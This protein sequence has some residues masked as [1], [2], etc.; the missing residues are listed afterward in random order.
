[1]TSERTRDRMLERLG[2]QGIRD[3]RVLMAMRQVPRHLFV[4]DALAHRA[5][6][7]TALPIAAGQTISQPYIVARMTELLMELRPQ[8][9][10]EVGTGSGYQA[11]VLSQLVGDVYTFERIHALYLHTRKLLQGLEYHNIHCRYSDGALAWKREAPF[12][13]IIVTAAPE[14]F[15]QALL[16]QVVTGGQIVVPVGG[17]RKQQK[18]LRIVRTDDGFTEEVIEDVVFVPMLKGAV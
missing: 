13:A 1:M 6:E 2:E 8:K 12:D 7:D 9:V 18:L 3:M 14:V 10:L 11:A 5:Y 4:E 16:Q 17:Y 15:P